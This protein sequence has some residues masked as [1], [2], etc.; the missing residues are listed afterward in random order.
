MGTPHSLM[1]QD[2]SLTVT[3]VSYL[4]HSLG[5]GLYFCNDAI[6]VFY[7]SRANWAAIKQRSYVL[8]KLRQASKISRQ[9]HIPQQ[10]YF[11]YWKWCQHMLCAGVDCYRQLIDHMEIR[12]CWQNK[13]GFL[14][15]CGCVSTT[16][17]MHHGVFNE[18][19]GKKAWWVRHKNAMR[20]FE[21]ICEETQDE[22]ADVRLLTSNLKNHPSKTNTTLLEI[23]GRTYNVRFLLTP[24]QTYQ[25]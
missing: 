10:Q 15:G 11:I 21:Q 8:N 22:T 13:T 17:W 18:K 14:P 19:N 23:Q 7:S 9:V 5:R 20:C 16:L 25:N 12:S 3:K 4:G 2:W 1:L 6:S 24:S